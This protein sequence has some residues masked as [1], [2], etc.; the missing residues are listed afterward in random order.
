M[1]L[2]SRGMIGTSS[3]QNE[4]SQP[5]SAWTQTTVLPAGFKIFLVEAGSTA[6]PFY[7]IGLGWVFNTHVIVLKYPEPEAG[8]HCSEF[9]GT[10]PV[11]AAV[12]A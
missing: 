5:G 6:A 3:E 1:R 2:P 12:V 8:S 4:P 7:G 11:E 10:V 9:Q